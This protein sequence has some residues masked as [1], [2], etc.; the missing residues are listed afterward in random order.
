M[1]WIVTEG[2]EYADVHSNSGEFTYGGNDSLCGGIPNPCGSYRNYT[3]KVELGESRNFDSF[4]SD[5]GNISKT[6][7]AKSCNQDMLVMWF[8]QGDNREYPHVLDD[9]S[10]FDIKNVDDCEHIIISEHNIRVGNQKFEDSSYTDSGYPSIATNPC[11]ST[12][13]GG[14]YVA[15]TEYQG[16]KIKYHVISDTIPNTWYT[17]HTELVEIY[18]P[19]LYGNGTKEGKNTK[20]IGERAFASCTRLSAVTF[21]AVEEIKSEA[22]HHCH[23]IKLIDWGHIDCCSSKIKKIGM[24]A[25][26]YCSGLTEL[27]LDK[28]VS[29]QEIQQGGFD[30]CYSVTALTLPTN[31]AYSA[32]TNG[33]FAHLNNLASFTIPSNIKSIGNSAFEGLASNKDYYELNSINIPKTI[34]HIGSQAFKST[35]PNGFVLNW[36]K[37]GSGSNLKLTDSSGNEVTF[38]NLPFGESTSIREFFI[39]GGGTATVDD[40]KTYFDNQGWTGYSDKVHN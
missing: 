26:Q 19:H 3:V 35:H 23:S 36:N 12:I 31:S 14:K 32:I 22:F 16:H 37:S 2:N 34:N 20:V 39:M 38:G 9:N 4:I 40:Y 33:C 8:N 17:G 27:C 15:G 7:T 30:S 1:A 6:I 28:L 18:F 21:S 29:I 10:I 24:Y 13:S 25:F 5:C 11:S